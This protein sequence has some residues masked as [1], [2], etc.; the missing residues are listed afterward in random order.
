MGGD[1]QVNLIRRDPILLHLFKKVRKMMGMAGID[2]HG[3]LPV[4]RIG[5]AVVLIGILP[6]ISIETFF[7]LHSLSFGSCEFGARSSEVK[8]MISPNSASLLAR[9]G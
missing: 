8:T 1:H 3:L 4:D 9:N 5:I 7:K 2:E 6:E